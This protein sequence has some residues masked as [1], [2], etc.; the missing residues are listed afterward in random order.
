MAPADDRLW[1]KMRD[2]QK[3]IEAGLRPLDETTKGAM[4]PITFVKGALHQ[5]IDPMHFKV[6][7]WCQTPWPEVTCFGIS[8]SKREVVVMCQVEGPVRCAPQE[9]GPWAEELV[10][11]EGELYE[12]TTQERFSKS[13]GVYYQPAGQVHEPEFF[14]PARCVI[15]WRREE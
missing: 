4:M 8:M 6:G 11:V 7:Q 5:P 9:H 12:H 13:T 10:M 1:C 15:T 3:E 14:G 2:L